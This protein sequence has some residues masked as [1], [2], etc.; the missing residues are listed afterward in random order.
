[1]IQR[2][3]CCGIPPEKSVPGIILALL[4]VVIMPRVARAKRRIANA[5]GS[6]AM[7]ADA[8]QADFCSYLSAILLSGL[9]LYAAFGLWWADALAALFMVP[10]IAKAG[11]DG[12]R[13][14]AWCKAM[15]L[16]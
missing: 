12:V 10:I 16:N 7:N 9:I 5:I 11:I 15:T 4:S 8:R 1:M 13:A 14:E 6:G 3:L 2:L